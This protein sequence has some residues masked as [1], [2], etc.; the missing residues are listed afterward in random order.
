MCNSLGSSFSLILARHV[1]K[2]YRDTLEVEPQK[3]PKPKETKSSGTRN[4]NFGRYKKVSEGG[5]VRASG[6]RRDT[7]LAVIRK[8]AARQAYHAKIRWI[9]NPGK[10]LRLKEKQSVKGKCAEDVQP[11]P[12]E[13]V[14]YNDQD[15]CKNR[16]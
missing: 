12:K 4:I 15:E 7:Q 5:P 1:S 16:T 6:R 10:R 9:E 14:R 2:V 11:T 3:S 13:I 8:A